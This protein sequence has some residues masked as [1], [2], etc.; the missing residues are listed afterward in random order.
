MGVRSA[1]CFFR[2]PPGLSAGELIDRA[3][4]KGMHV[5]DAA[6]SPV[7]AN[8]LVNRGHATSE[9]LFDLVKT[10]HKRVMEEYGVRLSLEVRLMG[11]S[12]EELAVFYNAVS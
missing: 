8:F 2:N 10:V 3:G 12:D 9:D 5:G 4:L 6:V 7:H 11:F 1:G